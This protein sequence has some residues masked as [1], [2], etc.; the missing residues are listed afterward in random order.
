MPNRGC[1]HRHGPERRRVCNH[2]GRVQKVMEALGLPKKTL[3]DKLNRHG[4]DPERFR[5]ETTRSGY[6]A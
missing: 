2:G 6:G 1:G 3:Y 4:I 5:P